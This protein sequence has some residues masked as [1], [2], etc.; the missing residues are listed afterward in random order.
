MYIR[1]NRMAKTT[2]LSSRADG[3]RSPHRSQL[4]DGFLNVKESPS[5]TRAVLLCLL[6]G[7]KQ[8][9]NAIL[10]APGKPQHVSETHRFAR[11]TCPSGRMRPICGSA[12]HVATARREIGPGAP[13]GHYIAR[14]VPISGITLTC[15]LHLKAY[16]TCPLGHC[17]VVAVVAAPVL[18]AGLT[19]CPIAPPANK[20][21]GSVLQ[22]PGPLRSLALV[23][24]RRGMGW[25]CLGWRH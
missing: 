25:D 8:Y 5:G 24:P 10:D 17:H 15:L 9:S 11:G 13:G 16:R 21:P 23:S 14:N 19:R 7:M 18:R 22:A 3:R 6:I 20:S 4:C 2:C 12:P 1:I